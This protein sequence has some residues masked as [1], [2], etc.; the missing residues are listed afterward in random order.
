VLGAQTVVAPEAVEEKIG[1][2]LIRRTAIK[3]KVTILFEKV[4][5][6]FLDENIIISPSIFNIS[7][8]FS[9]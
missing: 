2:R 4:F 6:R 9:Y 3:P 5:F 1:N 8:F 7:F